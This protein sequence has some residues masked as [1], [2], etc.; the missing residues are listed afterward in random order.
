MQKLLVKTL[1]ENSLNPNLK[2]F[3]I[4]LVQ[5]PKQKELVYF[6]WEY[7][8]WAMKE[9]LHMRVMVKLLIGQIGTKGN[10]MIG[11]KER[12]APEAVMDMEE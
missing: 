4:V 9:N 7:M 1:V 2:K 3:M 6:G 5:L 8:T 12:I 11:G 10:Q